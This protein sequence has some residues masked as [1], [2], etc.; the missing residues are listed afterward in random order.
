MTRTAKDRGPIKNTIRQKVWNYM[1]RNRIFTLGELIAIIGSSY[2][3]LREMLKVYE[4][5]G[6]VKII[7]KEKPMT[8]TRYKLIKY[9]GVRVPIYNKETKVLNDTNIGKE[10]KVRPLHSLEKILDCLNKELMTKQE[11]NKQVDL[12]SSTIVNCYAILKELSIMQRVIPTRVDRLDHKLFTIDLNLVE[13]LKTDIKLE[14]INPSELLKSKAKRPKAEPKI[15]CYSKVLLKMLDAMNKQKMSLNEI[16]EVADIEKDHGRAYWG[17][18]IRNN[19]VS[20]IL[21]IQKDGRRRLW[22][23]NIEEIP[24]LKEELV[25]GKKL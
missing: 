24:K 3:N 16:E 23:I 15:P 12:S 19:I 4:H 17:K 1:R 8:S 9:T 5:T 10:I 21:P 6:Y 2:K 18:L 22:K 20:E 25:A 7:S 14:K 13:N 11:I